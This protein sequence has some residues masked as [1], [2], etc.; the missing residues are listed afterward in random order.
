MIKIVKKNSFTIN[1]F[2]NITKIDIKLIITNRKEGSTVDNKLKWTNKSSLEM[3]NS[4]INKI[5]EPNKICKNSNNEVEYVIW[6]DDYDKV[7]F[8]KIR[9]IRLFKSN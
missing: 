6:Q 1:E 9:W 5:G 3:Y 7:D 2:K 4:L 8:G